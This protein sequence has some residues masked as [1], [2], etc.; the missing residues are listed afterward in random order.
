R[1]GQERLQV[2]SPRALA[3]FLLPQFGN[4]SVEQFGVVLLDTRHR[5][6]R[7][8][9]LSVGTLDAS[10]VHPREVFREATAGGAAAL[11][12]FHNHPSGDPDPST[13]DVKLTARM[14][15]AGALMGIEVI[16]HL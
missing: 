5:V 16:D 3:Q 14:V 4:R 1:S 8:T 6:L 11:V 15:G 13:D 10:I 2:S 12:L 9:V 7:T